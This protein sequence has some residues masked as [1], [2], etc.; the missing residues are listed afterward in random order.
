[1]TNEPNN[2]QRAG[3][4]RDALAT[5]VEQTDSV[6]GLDSLGNEDLSD[7]V[8]DLICDL[9]HLANQSGLDPKRII[10]QAQANYE[11]ELAAV[12]L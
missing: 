10:A 8:A 1:M 5:F 9:L 3:W 7:A 6:A 11:A 4:A 12:Q 2:F